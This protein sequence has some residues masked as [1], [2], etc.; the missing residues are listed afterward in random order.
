MRTSYNSFPEYHTSADN[1]GFVQPEYLEDTFF[2]LISMIE[3]L[4]KN[5][6]Y[7][8]KNPKC[9][10]QLGKRGIYSLI[11]GQ[12]KQKQIQTGMMWVLNY[13]DNNNDLLDIAEKSGIE[14]EIISNAATLLVKNS[15]LEIISIKRCN[16]LL[17]E[18]FT[19]SSNKISE[20]NWFSRQDPIS[21][22]LMV[23]VLISLLVM[24]LFSRQTHIL[25][26]FICLVFEPHIYGFCVP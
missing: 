22:D 9:E 20:L 15:L 3:I 12:K 5:H 1:L 24:F 11:G 16:I 25:Y 4:E 21:K 13:S 8:N 26:I 2:K 23:L 17:S 14:F 19:M 18:A 10:P 6:V 7:L